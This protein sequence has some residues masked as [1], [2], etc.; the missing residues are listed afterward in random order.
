[1]KNLL[2][3]EFSKSL[4]A[5]APNFRNGRDVRDGHLRG[6]GLQFGALKQLIAGNSL[7]QEALGLATGRTIQFEL[8]RMNMFLII[9]FFMGNLKP[10]HIV[11]FGSY[12]GGS[13]IFMAKVCSVLYPD[14]KI[15]AFDTFN[16]MPETDD[17]IDAHRAGDFNDV[18]YY[19]LEDYVRSIGLSNLKLVR[20]LFEDTVPV[21]FKSI[22]GIR[23]V[24]I[25]CDIR[26]AVD[27]SYNASK[28]VMVPGG[29]IVLDDGL[30]SSCLGATEV[31]ENL[32]IRRDGMNSEQIFPHFVFRAPLV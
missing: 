2:D 24:H 18:D 13:A 27:Y 14:M 7:Y 6:V 17:K 4:Q 20:G 19:E 11:E 15:Y 21:E 31:I 29:Y 28:S 1:M 26:S 16:G 30:F 12:K 10:G 32:M 8:N 3:L 25:D 5:T 9:K 22:G 23:M